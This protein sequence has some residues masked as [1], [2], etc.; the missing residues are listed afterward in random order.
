MANRSDVLPATTRVSLGLGLSMVPR[1]L[2]TRG[3]IVSE[4][5]A[6]RISAL[7]MLFVGRVGMSGEVMLS[8]RVVQGKPP[9]HPTE[10]VDWNT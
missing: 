5:S 6:A 4:G 3:L 1:F 8:D 9:S 2:H 7:N 10:Q